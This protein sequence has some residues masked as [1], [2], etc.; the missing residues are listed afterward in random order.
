MSADLAG[1]IVG[2][3]TNIKTSRDTE[4]AHRSSCN[5]L[6]LLSCRPYGLGQWQAALTGEASVRGSGLIIFQ[7]ARAAYSKLF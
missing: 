2:R 3:F 7:G 6:A 1:T 5:G 4:R